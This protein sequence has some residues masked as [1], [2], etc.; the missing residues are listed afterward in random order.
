[1]HHTLTLLAML[2]LISGRTTAANLTVD[3]AQT[4]QTIRGYGINV[5]AGWWNNGEVKPAIDLLVDQLGATIFRSV[6]EEMDWE[7]VNDNSDPNVFNW[8]Y[9]NSIYSNARFQGVWNTLR[10]L[11]Q[12]G[13]ASGLVIGFMGQPPAWMGGNSTVSTANEDEFV[14]T[15]TSLLYY[16]RNTAEIRFTLVS[17]INEAD[18]SGVEGPKMGAVQLARILHKLADKLDAIGMSDIR[19]VAPEAAGDWTSFFNAIV[20]D[21]VVMAKL[22]YW[23]VHN[24]GKGAGSFQNTISASVYPGK[25]FWVTE[26][27]TFANLLSQIPGNPTAHLVWDGFDSIYQHAIRAGRGSTLPNDSPGIEPPLIAYSSTTHLYT[28]RK[29]FFE[30][31]QLFRFVAPGAVRIGA[32]GNDTN[33]TIC[34]FRLPGTGRL[35][36]VGRNASASAITVNGTLTNLPAAVSTLGFY[37]TDPILDFRRGAD[38]PVSGGG[39]SLSLPPSSYFTLTSL[40][41]AP[42]TITNR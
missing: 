18:T 3:A 12:K 17:P 42:V 29:G 21:P 22:A 32:T 37:R 2:A 31:A 24:Y 7:A 13:I 34:A 35:T 25:P 27:A 33:L 28:P 6:I 1:M 23:G 26:T 11:N 16:A 36:I 9:Y 38:V 10:Y 20:A 40:A 15:M 8:T 4:Y 5:N 19:F 39:F 14:E 41:G 30:H